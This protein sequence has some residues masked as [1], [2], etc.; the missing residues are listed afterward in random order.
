MTFSSSD[1]TATAT[2]TNDAAGNDAAAAAGSPGPLLWV[3]SMGG[4]LIAVPV[5]ALPRWHGCTESG[6]V[7]GDGDDRD[8]YDRACEVADPAGVI[9]VGG[10]DA[11]GLVLA[12]QPATT[13]YLPEHHAFV[14][15]L[16]ADSEADLIAAARA[17]LADPGTAWE[18]CGVWETD[19]AAVLMDSVTAGAELGVEFP[20]GR[21]RPEQAPVPLRPGS[22]TVHAVHA[23]PNEYTSVGVVRLLPRSTD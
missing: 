3:E 11:R 2:A 22:W 15:W 6:M 4:P 19:G 10:E 13:C 21:G 16:G 8:D 18:E 5:S 1:A 14:R 9:A 23:S 7:I 20:D 12:D 17:V